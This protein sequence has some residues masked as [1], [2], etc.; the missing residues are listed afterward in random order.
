MPTAAPGVLGGG[1]SVCTFMAAVHTVEVGD[2]N[3]VSGVQAH[4]WRS[5][6]QHT[7]SGE[8]SHENL[9][10]QAPSHLCNTEAGA[11]FQCRSQAL[12]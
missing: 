3:Q 11:S 10:W 1:L 6:T 9:G 8:V 4:S 5:S 12:G 7:H 2:R